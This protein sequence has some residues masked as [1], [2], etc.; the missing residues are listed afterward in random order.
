MSADAANPTSLD[1]SAILVLVREQLAEILE[2]AP[3]TLSRMYRLA[4]SVQIRWR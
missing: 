3:T 1:R 2:K 4:I